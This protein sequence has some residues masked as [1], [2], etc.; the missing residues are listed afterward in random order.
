MSEGGELVPG[1]EQR[2]EEGSAIEEDGKAAHAPADDAGDGK[3]LTGKNG[4]GSVAERAPEEQA[5]EKEEEEV[6]EKKKV[7][8]EEEEEEEEEEGEQNKEEKEEEE[9]EE[10]EEEV[11]EGATAAPTISAESTALEEVVHE[12]RLEVIH[13]PRCIFCRIVSKE[14]PAQILYEDS[15]YVCFWDH[16]PAGTHHYLVVPKTHAIRDPKALTAEHVPIVERMVEIGKQVLTGL[17]GS[18]E[19]ARI[20]FHWPPVVWVKHLHLH[21][22]SPEGSMSWFNRKIMYRVDSFS[23]VTHTWMVEHLKSLK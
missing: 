10:K 20:G 11:S 2:K 1:G 7:A 15:H 6:Q 14:Q 8:D 23:F 18:L 13:E 3:A 19:A 21:V 17:G 12:P 22:I 4:E 5:Q 9:E 16:Q